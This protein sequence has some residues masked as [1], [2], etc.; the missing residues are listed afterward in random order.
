[1]AIRLIMGWEVITHNSAGQF[2]VCLLTMETTRLLPT[3]LPWNQP[4]LLELPAD[5]TSGLSNQ[6]AETTL[7]S[8]SPLHQHQPQE[9][10]QYPLTMRWLVPNKGIL[11]SCLS[12]LKHACIP[13]RQMQCSA[14]QSSRY[15]KIGLQSQSRIRL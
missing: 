5:R 2:D 12:S 6:H 1:M 9:S 10:L 4:Q 8:S 11:F 3:L 14:T 15:Q 13:P 7:L